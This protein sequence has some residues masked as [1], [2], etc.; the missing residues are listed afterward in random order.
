ML[1]QLEPVAALLQSHATELNTA[2]TNLQAV[3]EGQLLPLILTAAKDK[4][5]DLL[6]LMLDGLGGHD[7]GAIIAGF[8]AE[9]VNAPAPVQAAMAQKLAN[10]QATAAAID[11]GVKLLLKNHG[12]ALADLIAEA[13][14]QGMRI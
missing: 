1:T 13:E 11:P 5:I 8:Q 14:R 12:Q 3:D 9:L 2:A 10:A 7:F 4:R 6:R